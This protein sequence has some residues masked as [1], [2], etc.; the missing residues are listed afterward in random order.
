MLIDEPRMRSV[1]MDRLGMCATR[2]VHGE[3]SVRPAVSKTRGEGVA[4]SAACLAFE[5]RGCAY[6]NVKV[7]QAG[8]CE[9]WWW[10]DRSVGPEHR[11]VAVRC[12]S[13]RRALRAD[14]GHFE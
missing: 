10:G 4:A 7:G 13:R 12:A 1:S 5:E 14:G 6:R 9:L 3:S 8:E 2:V 11:R